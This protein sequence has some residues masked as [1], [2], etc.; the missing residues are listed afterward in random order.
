VTDLIFANSALVSAPER[1]V[2]RGAPLRPVPLWVRY[3]LYLGASTGPMLIDTGYTHHTLNGRGAGLRLYA[4]ILAPKLNLWA[5]PHAFLAAHG[6][7]IDD[8]TTVVVTHFHADHVSGLSLFPKARL[9]TSGAAWA[10]VRR[11]SALGNMRHGIFTE[12]LPPDFADRV[13]PMESRPL[14]QRG[15]YGDGAR[16]ILADG[17]VLSVDLPGHAEGHFGLFFTKLDRPL[18]Y[19][20][21]AQ[22]RIAA[23]DAARRPGFP[24]SL[25][26]DNRPALARSADQVHRFAKEGGDVVL[27]HDPAPTPYD[28]LEGTKNDPMA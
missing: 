17:S 25:I 8:I 7:T 12:L 24:S 20:V 5:Q 26:A 3:G 16:D 6:L 15:L 1:L 9:L 13:D 19:A 10:A 23:L 21:D 2:L 14:A 4:K 18:F 22:W 28:W 11:R 27:C